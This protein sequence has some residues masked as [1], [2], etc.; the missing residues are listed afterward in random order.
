VITFVDVA[1]EPTLAEWAEGWAVL[2]WGDPIDT[3]LENYDQALRSAADYAAAPGAST[4]HLTV[5]LILRCP[6]ECPGWI[7]GYRNETLPCPYCD[8]A[9]GWVI[10]EETRTP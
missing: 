1:E 5:A 8:H 9:T 2:S 10:T 4:G 6:I 7:T 3:G